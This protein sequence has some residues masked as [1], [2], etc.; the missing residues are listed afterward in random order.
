VPHRIPEAQAKGLRVKL[1]HDTGTEAR[2][3]SNGA[4]V[5]IPDEFEYDPSTEFAGIPRSNKKNSTLRA[6]RNDAVRGQW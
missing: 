3:S 6:V 1:L 2:R 5:L 4:V